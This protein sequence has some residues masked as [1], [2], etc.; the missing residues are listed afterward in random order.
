MT[1]WDKY[2]E[3]EYNER[4]ELI[5]AASGPDLSDSAWAMEDLRTLHNPT[6]HWCLAYDEMVICDE[7]L[8]YEQC[9]CKH[10]HY[11]TNLL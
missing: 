1:D 9:D 2:K 3:E 11:P 10:L 4:I 6:Y 7:D 8:E 5:Q